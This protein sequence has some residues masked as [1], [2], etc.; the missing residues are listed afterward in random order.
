MNHWSGRKHSE[1]SKSKMRAAKLGVPLT[2]EH[3]KNR[4]DSLR[5]G[6]KNR[7]ENHW[8]WKD[9]ATPKNKAIRNSLEF[10]LWRESVFERD[11]YTCRF[12]GVRGVELHPDHIKPFADYPELRFAIDN[13]RTLCA[14][15]HRATPTWGVHKK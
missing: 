1:E 12:C 10:K 5:R 15:C 3:T 9:G 13:G 4:V 14:P 7:G 6:G 8:N 11:D 2:A